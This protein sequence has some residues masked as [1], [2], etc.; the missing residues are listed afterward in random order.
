MAV[1]AGMDGCRGGWLC[2]TK[3]STTRV[4]QARILAKAADLLCLK[5][6]PN[7]VMVDIPIGL[8]DVGPRACDREAR[9]LLGRGRGSSVFPAPIRPMLAAATYPQACQIGRRTDGRALSKQTWN[10]LPKISEVD[11]FL[12]SYQEYKGR[13]R[14]THP[15]VCFWAW[16]GRRALNHGKKTPAGRAERESLV[17]RRYRQAYASAQ[18]CLPRDQYRPD[19]LLDAFAALWTA[20]RVVAGRALVIPA[21]PPVDSRGLRMEIVA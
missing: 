4:V 14:E 6:Q 13:M 8:T 16:N 21:E 12:R 5:P 7:V 20:E 11:T 10:I 3:D 2:L 19:D 15:E 1:V 9:Q 17:N 18:A